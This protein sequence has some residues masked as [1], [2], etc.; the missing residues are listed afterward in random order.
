M[1]SESLPFLHCVT[2]FPRTSF[3]H[4][5]NQMEC[6]ICLDPTPPFLNNVCAC[7]GSQQYIHVMCLN[8][9]MAAKPG[10]ICDICL[11]P[12]TFFVG[13]RVPHWY[14]LLFSSAFTWQMQLLFVSVFFSPAYPMLIYMQRI[15]W[16]LY[17][18]SYTALFPHMS[19][20]YVR[21]WL[22]WIV[23]LPSGECIFPLPCLI[24]YTIPTY[25]PI[26]ICMGFLQGIWRTHVGILEVM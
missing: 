1:E 10:G 15:V 25:F 13:R 17:T 9:W 8:A 26:L 24:M 16:F 5:Y 11:H 12:F 4:R 6:R 3:F 14:R 7:R 20:A 21:H 18:V 23:V 22:Q 19:W 2:K